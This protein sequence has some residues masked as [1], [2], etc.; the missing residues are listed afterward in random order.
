MHVQHGHRD[1]HGS[2][3]CNTFRPEQGIDK[4]QFQFTSERA[5]ADAEKMF[6]KDPR[7]KEIDGTR[8]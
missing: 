7:S 6:K 5:D 8:I 1:R 4:H 2:M 3:E